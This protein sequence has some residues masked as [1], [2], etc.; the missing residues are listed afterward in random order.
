MELYNQASGI[1]PF[2]EESL[3]VNMFKPTFLLF[4]FKIE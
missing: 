4:D 1:L 3:F 2:K